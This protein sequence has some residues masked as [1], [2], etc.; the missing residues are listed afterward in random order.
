MEGI[1]NLSTHVA[2]NTGLLGGKRTSV[3]RFLLL[4]LTYA[5]GKVTALGLVDPECSSSSEQ[6]DYFTIKGTILNV[7]REN[8]MYPACPFPDCSKKVVDQNTGLYRCEKCNKEYPNFTWRLLLNVRICDFS[9]VNQVT[10]FQD[11]AEKL[12]N[13][14]VDELSSIREQDMQAFDDLFDQVTFR[15]FLFRLRVKQEMYNDE[16]RI[17]FICVR[18][19]EVSLPEYLSCLEKSIQE[20]L[21]MPLPY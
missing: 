21:A 9:S 13:V 14:K 5:D 1:Q 11:T 3:C 8:C 20:L 18:V 15:N 19:E 10:M 6:G 2:G 7:N 16:V 17:R 4:R 12:L